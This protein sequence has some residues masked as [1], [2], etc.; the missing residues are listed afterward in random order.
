MTRAKPCSWRRCG[1]APPSRTPPSSRSAPGAA[2]RPSTSEQPPRRPAACCSASTTTTA[3]RR[4]RPAGS[5]TTTHW[6]T[7]TPGGSTP[8]P[9]G[10]RTM[11]EAELETS[12]VGLVGDSAVVASRW[13]TPLAFCFIDGGHGERAGLGRLPGLGAQGGRGRL[14][15]HPRRL[16]RPGR[17]RP[18]ALRHLAGRPRL[19]RFR[20]RRRVRVTAGPAPPLT[21]PA[22]DPPD[23]G[24][25]R[26]PVSPG[27]RRAGSTGA[28]GAGSVRS[29]WL[30]RPSPR[31]IPEAGVVRLRASAASTM[32]PAV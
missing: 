22:P 7:R 25:D 4:T 10:A 2:S 31:K 5:T 17:R 29:R 19:R 30:G 12:V 26:C 9:T 18:A 23:P 1:P 8:S 3:R 28:S 32:A 27:R 16:P 6:S 13:T 15:G 14:A 20:R 24:S 11:M 21:R